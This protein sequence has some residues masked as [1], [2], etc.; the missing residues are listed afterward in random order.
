LFGTR[1]YSGRCQFGAALY[2]D[3]VPVYAIAQLKFTDRA[4]GTRR[5]HGG[6]PAVCGN[7]VGH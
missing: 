6:F 7:L 5:H 3:G 1:S 4:A 2:G